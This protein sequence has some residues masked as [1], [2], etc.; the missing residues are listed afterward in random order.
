MI[1]FD[2]PCILRVFR[3]QRSTGVWLVALTLLSLQLRADA[4]GGAS[5]GRSDAPEIGKPL[6]VWTEGQLD[7]HHI[8]TGRGDST[9]CILPDGTT[10]LVDASDGQAKPLPPPSN[11]PT[12]PDSS[13]QA[14]EWIAR[15]I[16]RALRDIPDKKIDYAVLTHFHGDHIGAV[17]HETKHSAVGNYMLTGISEIPEFIPITKIID[18]DWP[19][20][21]YPKPMH[22]ANVENYRKFLQW[23]MAHRGLVVEQFQSG[24]NDQIAL[25]HRRTAYPNFEIRN[26]IA[27]GRVWTG[28]GTQTRELADLSRGQR[29]SENECSVAFRISYGKF[30]YFA[31][32]DLS[33]QDVVILPGSEPWR[34]VE[35]A[36]AKVCGPV[37]VMKANHHGSWD[38]NSPEFLALLRPRV[39]VVTSRAE[40]HPGA[41][42]FMRMNSTELWAGPRDIFITNTTPATAKTT[43][44]IEKTAKSTQGHVVIRVDAGGAIYHVYVLE[45]SD[46]EQRVKAIFGPYQSR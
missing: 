21:D 38:A 37:D 33:A 1:P 6:S 42:T 43:Y 20:Y 30:D 34:D 31:G 5:A 22:D 12:K 10:L 25:L 3:G 28:D 36:V 26:L 11:L 45:D 7:I 44:D 8:N 18:R 2:S 9:F 14:G 35:P 16:I 15:Y 17:R 41:N 4:P 32:G 23:Q 13:R 19:D 27:N 24:H 29:L 46:E 40:G 39:I